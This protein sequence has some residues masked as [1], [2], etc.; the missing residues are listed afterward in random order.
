MTKTSAD[1]VNQ[2][3]QPLNGVTVY[4]N[5]VDIQPVTVKD[6]LKKTSQDVSNSLPPTPENTY[7]R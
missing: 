4:Q 5:G 3:L 7:A 2:K 1:F 6:I